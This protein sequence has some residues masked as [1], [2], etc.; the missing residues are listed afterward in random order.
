MEALISQFDAVAGLGPRSGRE[1][2][3]AS[4]CL[5][6]RDINVDRPLVVSVGP[7]WRRTAQV[8]TRGAA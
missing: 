1:R 3:G 8:S 5:Q 2:I 6:R 7:A 4:T